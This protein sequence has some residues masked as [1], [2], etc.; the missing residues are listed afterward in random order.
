MYDSGAAAGRC[1]I[2]DLPAEVRVVIYRHLFE[3]AQLSLGGAGHPNTPHCGF[4]VC[5]CAFPWHILRTCRQLRWEALP[6]L[7]PATTL[8]VAGTLDKVNRLPSSYLSAIPR[9]IIL[10]AEAF[11]KMPLFLDHI[12]GLKILEIRNMTIWCR[13]HEGTYLESPAADDSMVDLA[14]FNLN[15]ISGHLGRLCAESTRTLRVFLRCQYVVSSMTDET[16]VWIMFLFFCTATDHLTERGRRHWQ[17]CRV[18]Q[19]QGAGDP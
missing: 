13:Y 11:S 2:L 19:V 18:V 17:E 9:A 8:Q 10:N 14:M 15:R 3:A 5:S 12:Q 16:I 6:Y 4:A 1:Y 7:L